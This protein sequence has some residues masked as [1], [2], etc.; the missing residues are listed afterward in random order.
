MDCTYV[1]KIITKYDNNG[2]LNLNEKTI[3]SN[4]SQILNNWFNNS[5]NRYS[6]YPKLNI[7]QSGSRAKSTAIKGKSDIDMF[8]SIEDPN[9]A[10]T[11]KQYYDSIYNFLKSNGYSV[12]KQNVS[13]GVKYNGCDIDVVPAKKVNSMSYQRYNDHYLWSN[14]HQCRMLTNIQKHIDL[15]QQSGI[16][17]EIMLLKVWRENHKLDF[18]SIYIEQLCVEEL[19][20]HNQ[21]NLADNFMHMLQYIADNIENKRIVDSSNCNN[22]ISDSLTSAEKK[23]ISNQARDSLGQKYWEPKRYMVD[24][25]FIID[26]DGNVSDQIDIVIYDQQYSPIVFKQNGALYIT[27]ESVYAVFEVKQE[28]NKANIEYAS[29]K[30]AS[31]RKLRRTSAPITYST[32]VKPA[33][34]LHKIIGGILTTHTSWNSPI[35]SVLNLHL[36]GLESNYTIDLIC[37]LKDSSFCVEYLEDKIT[38]HKNTKDEVLIYVFLEL[39]LMLQKIG[40]VPAIDLLQYAKAIDSI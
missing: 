34:P 5:F 37:C 31:V 14:K 22:I 21:Y 19:K 9:N 2:Q 35:D 11:L 12:R 30:I 26:S 6:Y 7:Q 18:P 8:L 20:R 24:K 36:K 38:L 17:K 28:L 4:L 23:R 13:I 32:G 40:T 1:N 16:R 33:K 15:V 29:E 39:L 25:A 27:A 3:Y 10:N